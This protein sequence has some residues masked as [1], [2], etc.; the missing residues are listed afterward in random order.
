MMK[1]WMILVIAALMICVSVIPSAAV[2]KVVN[3][4]RKEEKPFFLSDCDS[5]EGW[6]ASGAEVALDED[7]STEGFAS[8]RFTTDV[9]AYS[10][11]T[12]YICADFDEEFVRDADYIT[13]DFYISHPRPLWTR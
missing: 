5:I 6:A 2:N 13:F 10:N 11:A 8:V 4:D 7:E 9:T 1:R 3:N 12:I